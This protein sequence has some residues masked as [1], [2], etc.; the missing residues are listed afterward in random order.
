MTVSISR[1]GNS[2]YV[3]VVDP[4]SASPIYWMENGYTEDLSEASVMEFE[5][6][7]RLTML[8]P[9]G[10]RVSTIEEALV[11]SVLHA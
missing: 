10:S 4:Y 2:Q 11:N 5:M 1:L 6:A 9:R 7:L 3:V 8:Y